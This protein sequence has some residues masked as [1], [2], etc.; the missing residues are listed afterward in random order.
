MLFLRTRYVQ[1]EKERDELNSNLNL[2]TAQFKLNKDALKEKEF[3]LLNLESNL[4]SIKSQF[5]SEIA[6]FKEDLVKTA[7]EKK[8]LKNELESLET[9]SAEKLHELTEDFEVKYQ[10]QEEVHREKLT[11]LEEKYEKELETL[12]D[13]YEEEQVVEFNLLDAE[14]LSMRDERNDLR[15]KLFEME[16][17]AGAQDN[18]LQDEQ[19]QLLKRAEHEHNILGINCIYY[20]SQ[21]FLLI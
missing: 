2:I 10:K 4:A 3:A 14:L 19:N 12:E 20:S 18:K 6:H 9:K 8:K 16:S 15:E 21:I 1:L 13:R 7:E 5:S 17:R 11:A